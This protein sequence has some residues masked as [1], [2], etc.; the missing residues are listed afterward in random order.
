VPETPRHVSD[1]AYARVPYDDDPDFVL[2]R[3]LTGYRGG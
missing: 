1:A 2:E 3:D